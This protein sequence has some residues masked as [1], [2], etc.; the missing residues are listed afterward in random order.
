LT[1]ARLFLDGDRPYVTVKA[2][3]TKNKQDAR[4]YIRQPLAQALSA[5]RDGQPSKAPVFSLPD[6]TRMAQ[7]LRDDVAAARKAWIDEAYCLRER[8]LREQS[9]FLLEQNHSGE[10]LDFHS[11]RHTCGAWLA[12]AGVYPTVVQKIMRHSVITL[13]MD[14]YGHLFPGDEAAA[15]DKLGALLE[16]TENL[17]FE[18]PQEGAVEGAASTLEGAKIG[19]IER[20]GAKESNSESLPQVA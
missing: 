5:H 15:I 4:Q 13:T 7:M 11:L 6:R 3:S 9:D 17:P 8:N 2:R 14:T 12:K 19:K 16:G 1:N 10:C 20:K 18:Y